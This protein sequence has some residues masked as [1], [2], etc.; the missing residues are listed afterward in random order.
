MSD[1]QLQEFEK[2]LGLLKW[3]AGLGWALLVG[4]FGLGIWVA[5]IQLTQNN[6]SD[7]LIDQALDIKNHGMEINLLHVQEARVGNDL[8][9]IKA[10]L[11]R[12]EKKLP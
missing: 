11:E 7:R 5:T 12:I 9:H 8:L 2:Q 3:V 10:T 1:E 6:H 4:A